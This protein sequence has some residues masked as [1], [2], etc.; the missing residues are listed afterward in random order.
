MPSVLEPRGI[1]DGVPDLPLSSFFRSELHMALLE[2]VAKDTPAEA[3]DPEPAV[4]LLEQPRL[5]HALH[6]VFFKQAKKFT[7]LVTAEKER[8]RVVRVGNLKIE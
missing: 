6:T 7:S 3:A 2:C 5:V 1:M 4:A 8:F